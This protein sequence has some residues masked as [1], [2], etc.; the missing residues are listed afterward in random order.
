MEL[1]GDENMIDSSEEPHIEGMSPEDILVEMKDNSELMVDL[2]YSA[3]LYNNREIAEE[4]TELEEHLDKMNRVLQRKII[5][6][7][8]DTHDLNMALAYI[9]LGGSLELIADAAFEI[10]NVVL[11]DV[12]PHPVLKM[13]VQ[14]SDAVISM[15]KIS[16]ESILISQA[17]GV[18]RI[19]E[20][21]GM[22]I[23]AIKRG[24]NWIYGPDRDE[25]LM[26]NDIIFATGPIEGGDYLKR[27]ATEHLDSL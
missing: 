1:P 15:L 9:R 10:A 17:I 18:L 7:T 14:D 2:A 3:L 19:A 23:I 16:S 25:K 21:T 11:R 12:E 5:Q 22:W 6:R 8:M 4:I 13:S 27:A 20:N 24:K 26:P